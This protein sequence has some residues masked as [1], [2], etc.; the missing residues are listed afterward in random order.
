M[1]WA[2]CFLALQARLTPDP[3]RQEKEKRE[4]TTLGVAPLPLEG[5]G[6]APLFLDEFCLQV[7]LGGLSHRLLFLLDAQGLQPAVG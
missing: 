7:H 5:Q 1:P 4:E 6:E 3:S 2:I